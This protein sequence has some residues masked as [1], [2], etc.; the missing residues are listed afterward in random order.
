[1]EVNQALALMMQ[2]GSL[3]IALIGLIVT[4]VVAIVNRDKKK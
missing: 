3:I 1:M 4:I 2:F